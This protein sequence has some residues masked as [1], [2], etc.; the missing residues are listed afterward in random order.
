MK[1]EEE[2]LKKKEKN[3]YLLGPGLRAWPGKLVPPSGRFLGDW[4]SEGLCGDTPSSA[5]N[6]NVLIMKFQ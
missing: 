1:T 5:L 4:S 6:Q 3:F 2:K